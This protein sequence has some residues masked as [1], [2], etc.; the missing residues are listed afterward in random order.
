M[1]AK[2]SISGN[3]ASVSLLGDF[4]FSTQDELSKAFE[5]ALSSP[6]NDICIDMEKT[7]FIDS[8]VIRML[9]KLRQ[10]AMQRNK[11]LAIV[12]CNEHIYEIF[13]IGGFNHIFD[14]R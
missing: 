7:N 6:A 5:A 14:I 1:S 11:S 4:D 9:L 8:S 2:V 3:T 12:N 13:E 10:A